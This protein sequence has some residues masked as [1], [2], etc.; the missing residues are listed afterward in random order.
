MENLN[1]KKTAGSYDFFKFENVGDQFTG[2]FVDT[3]QMEFEHDGDKKT[4]EVL[5]WS[6]HETGEMVLISGYTKIKRTLEE[7][8]ETENGE[9]PGDSSD[10]VYRITMKAKQ[11]TKDNKQFTNFDIEYAYAPQDV[12]QPKPK[13]KKPTE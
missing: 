6:E 12:E 13:K 2:R 3:M 11:K 10:I 9:I 8:K 1:F 7:V 4:E 5:L